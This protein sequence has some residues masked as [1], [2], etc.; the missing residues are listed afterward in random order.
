MESESP[1]PPK[2][3][4]NIY[5]TFENYEYERCMK[6]NK[7]NWL[8][9]NRHLKPPRKTVN[10]NAVKEIL[11]QNLNCPAYQSVKTNIQSLTTLPSTS[12]RPN[13]SFDKKRFEDEIKKSETLEEKKIKNINEF[14]QLNLLKG[15]KYQNQRALKQT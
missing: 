5:T 2:Q 10:K 4:Q 13:H 7:Q 6:V 14:I 8:M 3:Q 11:L 15:G 1:S 9:L 12:I